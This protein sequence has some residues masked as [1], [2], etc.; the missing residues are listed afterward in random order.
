MRVENKLL[1][2]EKF[3]LKKKKNVAEDQA[4]ETKNLIMFFS[5]SNQFFYLNI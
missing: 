4:I 1:V 5:K 3:C 2:F